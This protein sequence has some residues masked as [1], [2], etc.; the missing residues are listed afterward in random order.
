MQLVEQG[1]IRLNDTVAHFI[2]E[3]AR[4]GKDRITI[5]HLLTHT[6]G[7]RPDLELEVR[8]QP[9]RMREQMPDGDAVLAVPGE[10][11]NEM[12]NR[13]VQTDATLFDELHQALRRR[14]DHSAR[15]TRMEMALLTIDL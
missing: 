13:V 3:F 8:P 14:H 5:R 15:E 7:L 10:L 12:R 4:H 11:G 6:S 2:P 9:G 1:R